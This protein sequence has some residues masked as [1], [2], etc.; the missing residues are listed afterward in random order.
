M[1]PSN[2]RDGFSIVEIMVTIG[3]IGALLPILLSTQLGVMQLMTR[4]TDKLS[5]IFVVENWFNEFEYKKEPITDKEYK[6]TRN[7]M[8][9]DTVLT[10][11]INKP[12]AQKSSLR[13]IDDIYI[14]RG[15]A[16]WKRVGLTFSD[17]M[18]SFMYQAPE[19]KKQPAAD[20]RSTK[21]AS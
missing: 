3:M 2:N 17:T 20:D 9:P 5:R 6:V 8:D 16:E 18:V 13:T 4:S 19:E 1:I 10:Y 14:V 12:D 15:K 11:V 21:A 7:V